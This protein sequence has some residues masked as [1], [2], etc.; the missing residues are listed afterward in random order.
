M[1]RLFSLLIIAVLATNACRA[2]QQALPEPSL[3]K[4]A[5]G[6]WIHKSYEIIEP[7]GPI[8]SQG[9]VVQTDRGVF[10]VD[11][12]WNDQDTDK[13]LTLIKQATGKLPD[14]AIVTHAHQDKMGGMKALHEAGVHSWASALTNNDA[15]TRDLTPA[16]S[17]IALGE[18]AQAMALESALYTFAPG[19]GHTR[20]NIVVYF[21]PANVL[22]GGCLIRPGDAKGLGNTADGDVTNWADAVRNVAN[23]FPEAEIVVPSHGPKGGRDLLDHT[24]A[25]AD[26]ANE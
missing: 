9:M 15:P 3:E 22:F 21:A 10:L 18:E 26:A 2:E 12:A 13:L 24:I 8:L 19:S 4:I 1:K 17:L 16:E 5:D 23:Q 25:L 11:T 14:A 20:D 7:W 6:V